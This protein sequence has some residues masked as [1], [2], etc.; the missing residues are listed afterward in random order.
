MPRTVAAAGRR[1]P[2]RRS[3]R[4]RRPLLGGRN[5]GRLDLLAQPHD[6]PQGRVGRSRPACP[7]ST[8][9]MAKR[10]ARP[11]VVRVTRSRPKAAITTMAS[12]APQRRLAERHEGRQPAPAR[13][14]SSTIMRPST[15]GCSPTSASASTWSGR[16]PVLPRKLG[17]AGGQEPFQREAAG[18]QQR[19]NRP[20]AYQQDL[21]EPIGRTIGISFRKLFLP[22]RFQRPPGELAPGARG[23]R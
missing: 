6:H 20:F 5:G 3:W 8:I 11:A 18:P 17:P 16:S 14:S 21:L 23:A 15:S 19:G 4:S 13:I 7:S 12:R 22:R 9:S 1:L 10:S 2:G